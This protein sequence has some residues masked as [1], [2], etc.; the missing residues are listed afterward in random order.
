MKFT[1]ESDEFIPL[2]KRISQA[3][4]FDPAHESLCAILLEATKD[5]DDKG[6][7]KI[8]S[9]DGAFWAINS[10]GAN[11]EEEGKAY[12]DGKTFIDVVKA[13]PEE[14]VLNF[15][16]TD[17]KSKKDTVLQVSCKK[18]KGKAKKTKF[19][20]VT[21]K[22]F[23]ET[24]PKE[25]REEAKVNAKSLKEAVT[26]VSFASGFVDP[27]DVDQFLCGCCIEI[28]KDDII[29]ITTDKKRICYHGDCESEE[30]PFV[31]VPVANYLVAVLP[32]FNPDEDVTIEAGTQYTIFKQKSQSYGIPN[33]AIPDSFP[34]WR[35]IIKGKAKNYTAEIQIS[36]SVLMNC[37]EISEKISG[38]DLGILV[39]YDTDE[40]T[41]VLST[42]RLETG[43]MLRASHK[44]T[45]TL[46]KEQIVGT[47][48]GEVLLPIGFFKDILKKFK[49]QDIKI[50]LG[51][52]N[53][54]I[55]IENSESDIKYLLATLR[56]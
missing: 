34:Q 48:K 43:G 47:A 53:N 10:T 13:Y 9:Q 2:A 55:F 51:P 11:V 4:A 5:D 35:E 24:P 42:S 33:A 20:L 45:E 54:P 22:H 28:Y 32:N 21:V 50:K 36:S 25:K 15:Q 31:I 8:I 26:A 40:K 27:N 19:N 46:E 14:A 56:T 38:K 7:I 6:S 37:V 17:G 3:K 49:N 52:S 1:V 39:E 29:A 16:T 44:E 12:V 18:T 30:K 41:L 23:D